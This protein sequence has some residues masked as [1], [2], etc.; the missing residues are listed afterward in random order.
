VRIL[1]LYFQLHL[2]HQLNLSGKHKSDLFQDA[3]TF[4]RA[5][6]TEYQPFFALLERNS[7]KFPE[8]KV[9]LGVSGQWFDQA[10][11]YDPGLIKRLK[12]LINLG[13]VQIIASPYD[14]SL[15][16]FLDQD[17]FKSQIELFNNKIRDYFGIEC[18]IFAMPELMYNDKIAAWAE[19]AGYSGMLIG[20]AEPI[21]DWRTPNRV[22]DAK[23]CKDFRLIC[24]N[25]KFSSA[26]LQ[27]KPAILG[28]DEKTGKEVFSLPKFQKELDLEFLRGNLINLCLDTSIFRRHHEKGI[29]KFFDNLIA[30]WLAGPQN[31]FYNALE[32]VGSGQPGSEISI[33]TTIMRHDFCPKTTD[34]IVLA[35]KIRYALPEG[36]N[37]HEQIKFEENL[38]ALRDQ[39]QKTKNESVQRDFSRLTA[40]DY[41]LGINGYRGDGIIKLPSY[42]ELSEILTNFG[43]RIFSLMP[44][45]AELAAKA[46]P[47]C[48][49]Q[50]QA[51]DDFSIKVHRLEKKRPKAKDKAPAEKTSAEKVRAEKTPAK[52]AQTE[53]TSP[54]DALAE[55]ISVVKKTPTTAKEI[56]KSRFSAPDNIFAN[57]SFDETTSSPDD[58]DAVLDKY[59]RVEVDLAELPEAELIAPEKH[60]HAAK[61]NHTPKADKIDAPKHK[62]RRRVVIE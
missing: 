46:G 62:K 17:E 11:K 8:F 49:E 12:K 33:K 60:P 27:T 43:Q 4:A 2:P 53:G 21:L 14:F 40:L 54:D 57:I 16:W 3:E 10:E 1:H 15:S 19:R 9:S 41:A 23:G 50:S 32:A 31:R 59:A 25:T 24:Q 6:E 44:R 51:E 61:E 26:I 22:Y 34:G 45:P 37:S 52:E 30:E 20:E 58:E 42:A 18:S 39:A 56:P 35:S 28:L 7:Q 47:G 55:E 5:N 29:I 48:I 36:L 38:Y 13:R